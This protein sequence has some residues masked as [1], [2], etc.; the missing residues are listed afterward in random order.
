MTVPA[1][2][3]ANATPKW[4]VLD[5]TGQFEWHDHRIHYLAAGVPPQVTDQG[6]LTLVFPWKVP[7]A[8]GAVKG[9]IFGRLY[10]VPQSSFAPVAVIAL[11]VAIVLGGLLFVV[12]VRRRRR[13]PPGG[14][15]GGEL[16]GA[17]GEAW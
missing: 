15:A 9:A 11:G 5:R 6:K 4:E 16:G 13:R 7:I 12:F 1:N 3:S 14:A 8:V 10:W 17:R 2:A